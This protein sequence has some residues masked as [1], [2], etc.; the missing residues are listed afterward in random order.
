MLIVNENV[1]QRRQLVV[2]RDGAAFAFTFGILVNFV[3]VEFINY[4]ESVTSHVAER[5]TRTNA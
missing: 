3:V 4:K 5:S 1:M 2:T